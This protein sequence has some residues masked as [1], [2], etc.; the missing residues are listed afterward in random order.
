MKRLAISLTFFLV[1][2]LVIGYVL[3]GSSFMD[4][5]VAGGLFAVAVAGEGF[6]F[7]LHRS[8]AKKHQSSGI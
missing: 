1:L 7:W 6:R 3:S 8:R 4:W 2:S 5:G